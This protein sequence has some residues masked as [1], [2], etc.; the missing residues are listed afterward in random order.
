MLTRNTLC[1]FP[2][3]PWLAGPAPEGLAAC[4]GMEGRDA[5]GNG[6]LSKEPSR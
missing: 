5:L 4:P 2:R 6:P 1:S 3:R